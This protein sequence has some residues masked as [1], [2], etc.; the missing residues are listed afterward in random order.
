MNIL[1]C[2]LNAK[3]IH[4]NPAVHILRAAS[5]NPE[6]VSIAEYTINQ[7]KDEIL[8]DLYRRRPDVIAF[9]CYI[10]NRRMVAELVGDLA[11]ILPE[12]DLW[13]G[14]PEV[15][16][17][18]EQELMEFPQIR[19]VMAG[20]GEVTFRKL[21][22]CYL[23]AGTVA[24]SRN[25]RGRDIMAEIP[26][27]WMR[28]AEGNAHSAGT[29]IA[30]SLDEIPFI[31]GDL[32]E[33]QNRIIYYESS[34]GC[35]FRCSYCLS[36]IDKTV[37][38]RSLKLVEKE[39]QYFL[40]RQ[41]KQVKFI[42]RTFNCNHDHAMAIWRYIKEHDNGIT[43]FHFEIA[44]DLITEEELRLLQAMRPG[45]VQLEIGVQS[46]NEQ[47]LQAVRRKTNL[48]RLRTVTAQI[49]SGHNIHQ[50]LDLIAGLPY[51]DL[52]SFRHSFN[53]VYRMYPDQLQLG[54]LKVLKGSY[55]EE[56]CEEYHLVYRQTP[57][58]EV[59]STAWISYEEILELKE[60]EEMVEVYYNSG[61]FFYSIAL[62]EQIIEEPYMLYYRLAEFYRAGGYHK[63]QPA[64]GYRYEILLNFIK[65]VAAEYEDLAREALTADLYLRERLKSRPGYVRDLREW[66]E[67]IYAREINRQD[68]IDVF[69]YPVWELEERK[70][71]IGDWKPAQKPYFV[72]FDYEQRNP[73]TGNARLEVLDD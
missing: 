39:L 69:F 29:A 55:M 64:R 22:E 45:L 48:A 25:Q 28:D 10:W 49:R 2:A 8:A 37:R 13:L 52:Q 51:E 67:A 58:Y 43:N 68:H 56:C 9:S 14:G 7:L 38:F 23:Q 11:L 44:A 17:D 21:V 40:D 20:E 6:A 1:L 32:K 65:S 33:F 26:G 41:V 27:I 34:R 72:R 63:N 15:S 3:Y 73:L 70:G 4:S 24:E 30:V 71:G 59:L 53:E 19:G 42:D 47:T 54:F 66:K 36:S 5:G 35:P 57:P 16:Y 50:H 61:Q 18:A 62:L 46:V 60:I 12:T 31:Y